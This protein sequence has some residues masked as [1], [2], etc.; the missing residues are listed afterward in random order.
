MSSREGAESLITVVKMGE[1]G[2]TFNLYH[3]G[4][5]GGEDE[6]FWSNVIAP[7]DAIVMTVEANLLT[8]H[9]VPEGGV[10]GDSGSIVFRT[11][12]SCRPA[13]EVAKKIAASEKTKAREKAKKRQR[14]SE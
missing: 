5:E 2:R 14:E 3:K 8:K 4:G 12:N 13:A 1:V 7:G 9:E 11:L 6:L 10:D